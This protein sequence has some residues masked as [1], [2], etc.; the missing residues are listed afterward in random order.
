[1]K[2]RTASLERDSGYYRG[3][4]ER[5]RAQL[6]EAGIVQRPDAAAAERAYLGHRSRWEGELRSLAT[7]LGYDW[8]EVTGDR[9]PRAAV[10]ADRIQEDA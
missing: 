4:I 1:L 8:E 3:R 6:S 9:D 5:T 10:D 7:L 2:E